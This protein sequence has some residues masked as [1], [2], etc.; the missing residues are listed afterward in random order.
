MKHKWFMGTALLVFLGFGVTGQVLHRSCRGAPVTNLGWVDI[1]GYDAEGYVSSFTN[2]GTMFTVSHRHPLMMAVCSPITAVGSS[3]ALRLGDEAGKNAA[4]GTFALVGAANFL[5]LWL[6][7]AKSGARLVSRISAAVLWMSFAHV[8]ILGSITESFPI[9]MT[10]LLGTLLMVAH[11]VRDWRAWVSISAVAGAVTVTNVLKPPLAWIAGTDGDADY[12]LLRR[13]VLLLGLSVCLGLAAL[14]AVGVLLKWTY[15][16]GFG[17]RTGAGIVWNEIAECLPANTSW[18]RR[19]WHVWNNLWCEP[20]MLHGKIIA[21]G[22]VACPYGSP[23]PHLAGIG[24]LAL[25]VLSVIRNFRHP[26][27]R[28]LLSMLAVDV[29]IHVICGWGLSEGQIYCGHWLFA[30][31]IL[32]A[33]LPPRLALVA[34]PLSAIAV[35]QSLSA[36]L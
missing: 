21:N 3:V 33:L 7:M 15:V 4:I 23:L 19:L 20:M 14:G 25:C 29:F 8:W 22:P 10:I 31:P 26:L 2:I 13:R 28:A 34:L 17:V 30:V 9:S 35:F 24:V 1:V 16:D 5:L 11:Q 27:V 12:R 18:G 36:I 32:V 6:V